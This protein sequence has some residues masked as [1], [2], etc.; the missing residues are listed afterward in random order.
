MIYRGPHFLL[1]TRKFWHR[2]IIATLSFLRNRILKWVGCTLGW[3]KGPQL[4]CGSFSKCWSRFWLAFK[5]NPTILGDLFEKPQLDP[6][7]ASPPRVARG[8][9]GGSKAGR[10]GGGRPEIPYPTRRGER[11]RAREHAAVKGTGPIERRILG[12]A[13]ENHLE[14]S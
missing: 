6:G 9:V 11:A 8:S 14:I 10:D 7:F 2:Y 12:Q 4:A 3:P 1:R 13:K 5:G